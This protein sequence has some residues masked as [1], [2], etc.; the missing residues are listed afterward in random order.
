M[1]NKYNLQKLSYRFSI[2][3]YFISFMGITI[4]PMLTYLTYL[5]MS[6]IAFLLA[7]CIGIGATFF[8]MLGAPFISKSV[9]MQMFTIYVIGSMIIYPVFIRNM[10]NGYH[11]HG[12][13]NWYIV[14]FL[15]VGVIFWGILFLIRKPVFKITIDGIVICIIIA[16]VVLLSIE[17]LSLTIKGDSVEYYSKIIRIGTNFSFS[18]NDIPLLKSSGHSCYS[19]SLF[20]MI[21][22]AVFP[23][24]A[25]GVRIENII[26]WCLCIWFVYKIIMNL[27]PEISKPVLYG[28]VGCFAFTPL[29]LST[30]QEISVELY[31]IFFFIL[32]LYSYLINLHVLEMFFAMCFVFAKEPDILI[33]GG[34]CAGILLSHFIGIVKQKNA[35]VFD[36]SI[37]LSVLA[38]YFA[39]LI[40]LLYFAV[41]VVWGNN[42]SFNSDGLTKAN[43]FGFNSVYIISK[44]KQLF[45]LNFTWIPTVIISVAFIIYI[46][47]GKK[48]KWEITA[49]VPILISYVCFMITQLFYVT[50]VLPRYIMLQ[51]LFLTLAVA[52]LLSEFRI[53]KVTGRVTMILTVLIMLFQNFYNIDPISYLVFDKLDTG[54]GYMIF[55]NPLYVNDIGQLVT[56]KE[57][58][59]P[60]IQPYGMTNRQF[61]YF[62]RLMERGFQSIEFNENDLVVLPHCFKLYQDNFYWGNHQTVYFYDT[63]KECFNQI[64]N[65]EVPEN[66]NN[67][68]LNIAQI[69][70]DYTLGDMSQ[71][72]NM[73]YFSFGFSDEQDQY[74]FDAY[75][76]EKIDSISYR[77][78][79]L[80]IYRMENKK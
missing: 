70:R 30:I 39:A 27:R 79:S 38:M 56:Y 5:R 28:C 8:S 78:W 47:K 13:F 20:T 7:L 43:T 10:I 18:P 40:F 37:V 11:V 59:M 80:D 17:Q 29:I 57:G 35:R 61:S 76:T 73:Y 71:F 48:R 45:I 26:V 53:S 64:I 4:S 9:G 55:D 14:V 33:L 60:Y 65:E 66:K 52:C 44:I 49:L 22:E 41:D 1:N 42:A 24:H 2:L 32:F 21:G 75:K 67:I 58:E 3:L 54:N 51:Y 62:D 72:D 46:L 63:E 6:R 50:F 15:T 34:F 16:I 69:A 25:L 74:V 77:G 23:Y 12:M 68:R 31:V 19:Y 36:R